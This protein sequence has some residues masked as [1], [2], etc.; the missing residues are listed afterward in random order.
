MILAKGEQLFLDAL[1]SKSIPDMKTLSQNYL[2]N[3]S[4]WSIKI[5]ILN[6]MPARAQTND[7]LIWADLQTNDPL[8]L[9]DT[10][11]LLLWAGIEFP[12]SLSYL[13]ASCKEEDITKN[14][15]GP[16]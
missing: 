8:L 7:S 5:N 12:I 13:D 2:T 14:S 15:V 4:C 16:Q 3:F 1:Q 9:V 10:N 11:H 6:N